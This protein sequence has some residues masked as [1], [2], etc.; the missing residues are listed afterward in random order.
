MVWW[1]GPTSLALLLSPSVI[2]CNMCS[3]LVWFFW[4]VHGSLYLHLS[5]LNRNTNMIRGWR[6]TWMCCLRILELS[7][8]LDHPRC[9]SA[10]RALVGPGAHFLPNVS[11]PLS[12]Y[13]EHK[14]NLL[15]I[16]DA[17]AMPFFHYFWPRRCFH[18]WIL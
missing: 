7:Q 4:C 5:L 11:V 14:W 6:W 18:V 13:L 8:H 15:V 17:Y 10:D 1:G 3:F 9:R 2:E 12:K 16:K